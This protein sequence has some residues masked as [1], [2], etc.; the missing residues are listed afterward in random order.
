MSWREWKN[1]RKSFE[2]V[3]KWLHPVHISIEKILQNYISV[4]YY[5]REELASCWQDISQFAR[6]EGLD[7]HARAVELRFEEEE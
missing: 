6:G 2:N 5:S 3:T 1:S 7:A 4:L